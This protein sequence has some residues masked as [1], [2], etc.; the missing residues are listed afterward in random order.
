MFKFSDLFKLRGKLPKNIALIIEI[1]GI[2]LL[3]GMWSLITA[4]EM[5]PRSILPSPWKVLLAF[6]ELWK[7]GI[8][9][10]VIYSLKI[11]FLGY[12]EAVVIAIPVGFLIG[13]FPLFRSMFS[14]SIDS[15]RYIP[16]TAV[17]GLFIAW[18]GIEDNMK[19]QFLAF[20]IL[21][22]LL[23]VVVQRIDEVEDVYLQ[24]VFTLGANKW[25]TIKSVYF[26]SVISRLSDDIRVLV[27]ISW[28][29]I[30]VTEMINVSQGVG[31]M[32]YLSA[33]QSRIDK[34]F[35]ILIIIIL[36]GI[37]QDKLFFWLDKIIFPHKYQTKK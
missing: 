37:V 23:P 32:A 24:T 30:I 27:A 31:A 14:K 25:Q 7:A 22:Y 28:T 18:F 9:Y 36:I 3:L 33:R 17:T 16:L 8:I 13:L 6:G 2:L 19:I 5:V 21:V 29:Y 35:A 12:I 20:G 10:D 34:V 11:N 4:L 15:L 1:A 26:P